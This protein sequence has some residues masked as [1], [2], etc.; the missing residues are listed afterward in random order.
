MSLPSPPICNRQLGLAPE[1]EFELLHLS[2][3]DLGDLYLAPEQI[4]QD[5]IDL[6]VD[7]QAHFMVRKPDL[8]VRG[9]F[10]SCLAESAGTRLL[11]FAWLRP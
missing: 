6:K 5:S 10:M 2:P 11:P 9:D 4:L 3:D 7:P 1:A 8:G